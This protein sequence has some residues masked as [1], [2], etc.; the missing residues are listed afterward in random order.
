MVSEGEQTVT[1]VIPTR[2]RRRLL[3]RAVASVIEAGQRV[4]VIDD[5][6]VEPVM[7]AHASVLVFRHAVPRGVAAARNTGIQHVSTPWVAFLDDD[8][9]TLP[10]PAPRGHVC[11]YGIDRR[12]DHDTIMDSFVPHV[13]QTAVRRDVCPLFDETYA[14]CE[15]VEWWLRLCSSA[16]AVTQL[17]EEGFVWSRHEGIRQGNGLVARLECSRRLLVDHAD[18]FE[19]HRA[20]RSFRLSRIAALQR[21]RGENV[22]A[23]VSAARAMLAQ[24]GRRPVAALLRG[25]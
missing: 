12:L 2:D 1:F 20:A 10:R 24:P 22:R 13:G 16:P 15:D 4:V 8:D 17:P 3:D 7:I 6:S 25:V 19:A 23:T 14:A 21:Q 18:Y 5:G 9:I 11:V